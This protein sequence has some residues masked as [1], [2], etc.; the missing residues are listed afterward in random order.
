MKMK[1]LSNINYFKE[2]PFFNAS[3]DKLKIKRLTNI[4]LL[5]ELPFYERLKVTKTDQAF[6]GY[7]RPYKVEIIERKDPIVQLKASKLS[8]KNLF[9]NLINDIKDFKYQITVKV[10]LKKYKPNG[11]IE[12]TPVCFNSLTKLVINHRHKLNKSFQEMLYRIDTWINERSGWTVKSI[13]SQ[14]INISTFKPL[15]GSSYID[16][17][18]KLSN[19][20]KGLINVKNNDQKCFLWCHVRH[21]NPIEEH[22]G[23]IKKTDRRIA[24]NLNY[25]G[26]E[27]PVQ[28]KDFKKIEVQN[29]CIN[30]FCYENELV[31]PIF[32]SKQTFED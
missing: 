26:I 6:S 27:F 14:Y 13:E 4:N 21:I 18:V 5:D 2:L 32:I 25:E 22:P 20:R 17:P 7:A 10:L 3:I 19:P 24:S 29:I 12:F 9:S 30:V 11:E 15:V 28:E 8:I 23:R 16:L 31:Y 1:T